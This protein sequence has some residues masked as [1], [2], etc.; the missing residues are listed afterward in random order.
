[1]VV[2]VSSCADS[3]AFV[4]ELRCTFTDNVLVSN[5]FASIVIIFSTDLTTIF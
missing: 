2:V 3:D 1:M 5:L 4:D